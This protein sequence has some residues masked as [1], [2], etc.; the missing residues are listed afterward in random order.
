MDAVT[1]LVLSETCRV[2]VDRKLVL[3]PRVCSWYS[4]DFSRRAEK[5]QQ[6][7]DCVRVISPYIRSE[8]KLALMQL[9]ADGTIPTVKYSPFAFQCRAL[10][11]MNIVS[12]L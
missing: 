10:E 6:E 5:P 9:C 1:Q 2:D 11:K 12:N 3:L 4:T 8:D 7:D